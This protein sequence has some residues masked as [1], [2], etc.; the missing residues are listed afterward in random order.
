MNFPSSKPA[1]FMASML[2]SML[3]NEL[4]GCVSLDYT[5]EGAAVHIVA[6]TLS[7]SGLFSE[8]TENALMAFFLKRAIG[9]SY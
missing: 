7:C 4:S 8:A 2:A 1:D 3:K 6:V 9:V 5:L